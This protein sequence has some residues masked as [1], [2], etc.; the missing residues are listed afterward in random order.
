MEKFLEALAEAKKRLLTA[1]HMVSFT[2]PVVRDS[3]LLISIVENIFLALASTLSSLLYYERAA[4]RIPPFH[5][6]FESKFYMFKEE[7]SKAY[8]LQQY[9]TFLEEIRS[10]MLAH[11]ESPVEFSRSENFVMCSENYSALKTISIEKVQ[12]YVRATKRFF[13]EAEDIIKNGKVPVRSKRRA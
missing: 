9:S 8:N 10:L 11:R 5:D 7:V 2:Y 6:N 4:K 3:R 13:S 1:D 12:Q